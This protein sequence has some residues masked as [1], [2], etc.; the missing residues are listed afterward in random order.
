ME[1][2]FNKTKLSDIPPAVLVG[3]REA[4]SSSLSISITFADPAGGEIEIEKSKI[5]RR[6]IQDVC[7][8]FHFNPKLSP[9]TWERCKQWDSDAS[10][11]IARGVEAPA[12][13]WCKFACFAVPI[14]NG[15]EVYGLILAGERRIKDAYNEAE[16]RKIQHDGLRRIKESPVIKALSQ[17]EQALKLARYSE[18]FKESQRNALISNEHF[19]ECK[20]IVKTFGEI[21]GELISRQIFKLPYQ[22]DPKML[23]SVTDMINERIKDP[24]LM[25]KLLSVFLCGFDAAVSNWLHLLDPAA[26]SPEFIAG[27]ELTGYVI[28][29]DIRRFT[30]LC[31]KYNLETVQEAKQ[32]LFGQII[33]LVHE[34]GGVVDSFVGDAMVIHFSTGAGTLDKSIEQRVAECTTRISKVHLPIDKTKKDYFQLGIGIAFGNFYYAHNYLKS[35]VPRLEVG[36]VGPV[37][38]RASRL[39]DLSRKFGAID[40]YLVPPQMVFDEEVSISMQ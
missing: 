19:N 28:F 30:Q 18:L 5:G 23:H 36:I 14:K 4:L 35:K 32:I 2:K 34:Y 38:N 21:L 39:C 37:V 13:C 20:T 17:D 29:I 33:D 16:Y 25:S 3:F 8:E 15:G 1:M 11:A 9:H 31:K 7:K 27:Q 22:P 10:S 26:L 6:Y 12:E 24:Q 40:Q